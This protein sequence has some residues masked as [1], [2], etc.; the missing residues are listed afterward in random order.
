MYSVHVCIYLYFSIVL[1]QESV[2]AKTAEGHCSIRM[3]P[4]HREMNQQ[5]SKNLS[6]DKGTIDELEDDED[7]KMDDCI[8]TYV[9]EIQ[10]EH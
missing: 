10:E 5:R 6:R 4:N 8:V 7:W 3:A 2:G 9:D 1:V